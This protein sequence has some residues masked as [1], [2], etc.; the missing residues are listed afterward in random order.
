[1]YKHKQLLLG[2]FS[3]NFTKII[4]YMFSSFHVIAK[5]KNF[6]N[7][8]LFL[9]ILTGLLESSLSNCFFFLDLSC[10]TKVSL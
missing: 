7:L 4:D 5:I 1:M 6:D 3:S 9:G 2:F 10:Y 8:K